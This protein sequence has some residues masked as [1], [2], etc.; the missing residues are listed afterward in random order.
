AQEVEAHG[1]DEIGQLLT[2][3]KDMQRSLANVVSEVRRNAEGVA[4]ASSQIA[5]GNV[6]ISSRTEE[7]AASLEET[8]ANMGELTATVRRN[9][10]SA[11][12]ATTL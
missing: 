7:Q 9:S 2:A 3:L 8:A 6:N 5:S 12:Q 10:E 1:T 4:S 11:V